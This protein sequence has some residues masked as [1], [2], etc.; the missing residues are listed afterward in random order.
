MRIAIK[1]QLKDILK[2]TSAFLMGF[3]NKLGLD[4]KTQEEINRLV[5]LMVGEN[6]ILSS[7]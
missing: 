6:K 2:N 1:I 5:E 3:S 7:I 4:S